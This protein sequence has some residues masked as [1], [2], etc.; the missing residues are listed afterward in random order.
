MA[1]IDKDKD[2]LDDRLV[3]ED[4]PDAKDLDFP[5]L[6][7]RVENVRIVNLP[8]EMLA[9]MHEDIVVEQDQI[10]EELGSYSRELLK[11]KEVIVLNKVDLLD[12]KTVGEII[13]KFSKNLE[14]FS[15]SLSQAD[16]TSTR[17]IPRAVTGLRG[18]VS[19]THSPLAS[20]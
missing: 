17:W 13:K 18:E 11:K 20:P 12:K 15:C 4:E 10:K 8:S 16:S 9:D 7:S 14:Y 5:A 3:G 6:L 2:K 19:S 1:L